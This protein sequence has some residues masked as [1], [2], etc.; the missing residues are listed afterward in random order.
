MDVQHNSNTQEFWLNDKQQSEDMDDEP[1]EDPIFSLPRGHVPQAY[2][3]LSSTS[4]ASMDEHLPE[5]NIG[6]QLLMK[7]GWKAGEG[8]GSSQQG[9]KV[10]IR[11]DTKS[12]SLGVGKLEEENY[13]HATSTAKRKALDSEK[14][15][16]ETEEERIKR[17]SKVQKLESIKKELETI[18]AAFY[19]PLCDKQYTKIT[20]YETHLSSYDHNHR[21][22]FKEMNKSSRPSLELDKKRKRERKR[23]EKEFARIQQAAL[24]RAGNKQLITNNANESTV[25]EVEMVLTNEISGGG[26]LNNNSGGWASIVKN[27]NNNVDKNMEGKEYNILGNNSVSGQNDNNQ[28]GW[29]FVRATTTSNTSGWI[30]STSNNANNTINAN[31]PINANNANYPINANNANNGGWS[32]TTNI[33]Q[34]NQFTKPQD[35]LVAISIDNKSNDMEVMEV[36]ENKLLPNSKL[37]FGIN[38]SKGDQSEVQKSAFKFGFKKK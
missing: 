37:A 3:D 35:S 30:S 23:E 15:A 34:S 32:T 16:E 4:M 27:S 24:Q 13:Y 18:N 7:M 12:D 26:T 1:L 21:K 8:L 2:L 38:K 11:I 25:N 19:C 6:Y 31:Y 28:N 22:R 33:F 29:N 20:E 10:P 14:I 9:R 36:E 17:Q 5:D